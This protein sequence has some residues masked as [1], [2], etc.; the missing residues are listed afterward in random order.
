MAT[1][2]IA[3]ADVDALIGTTVRQALFTDDDAGSSYDST[4]FDLSL[5][6]I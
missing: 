5:I 3:A 6:H 2:Y 4:E 1:D